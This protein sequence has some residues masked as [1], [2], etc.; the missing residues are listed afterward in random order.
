MWKTTVVLCLIVQFP[1]LAQKDPCTTADK[2]AIKAFQTLKDEADINQA[3]TLFQTLYNEFSEYAELPFIMAQ[4]SYAHH[5]KL[6]RDPRKADEAQKYLTQAY[7]MFSSSYKKCKTYHAD[8][9]YLIA[10]VLVGQGESE[11][12]IP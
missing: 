12:A 10:S 6:K 4:K 5:Q 2:K 11:K 8:N 7:L 3:S 1:L 9:L